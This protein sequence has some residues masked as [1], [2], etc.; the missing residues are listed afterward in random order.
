M[1]GITKC[2]SYYKMRRST[3]YVQDKHS[4]TVFKHSNT[5]LQKYIIPKVVFGSD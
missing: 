2:N 3:G 4:N 5:A 1:S